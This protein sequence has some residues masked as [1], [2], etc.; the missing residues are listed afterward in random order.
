MFLGTEA[1][2]VVLNELSV[3]LIELALPHLLIPFQEEVL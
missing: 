2:Q 3:F 1:H